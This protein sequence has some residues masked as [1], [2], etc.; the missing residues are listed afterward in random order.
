LTYTLPKSLL[1][2]S[3]F[4]NVNVYCSGNDLLMIAKNRQ[5][6]ELNIGTAPQT[7]FYNV[8]IKAEF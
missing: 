5:L 6:M 3:V 4:K 8:G 1:H 7:R 2:S